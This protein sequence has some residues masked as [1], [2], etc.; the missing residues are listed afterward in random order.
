MPFVSDIDWDAVANDYDLG[1][2]MTQDELSAKYGVSTRSIRR[3]LGKMGLTKSSQIR[4]RAAEIAEDQSI[5]DARAPVN[6]NRVEALAEIGGEVLTRHRRAITG[7]HHLVVKMLA[8]LDELN[9]DR[10]EIEEA[11]IQYFSAKVALSPGELFRIK[12]QMQAALNAISLPVRS[13]VTLNLISAMEKVV[14]MERKAHK[15]DDDDTGEK[16][17][18]ETLREMHALIQEKKRAQIT[19]QQTE[20]VASTS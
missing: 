15:L 20:P 1:R 9:D 17:Y 11:V 14:T 13:K 6:L 4:A 7:A 19:H 16:T 10:E 5:Q 18:E 2:G 3:Q 12:A 8:E